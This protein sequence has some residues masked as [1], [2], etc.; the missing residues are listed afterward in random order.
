MH[1]GA[2]AG[3]GQQHGEPPAHAVERT[4]PLLVVGDLDVH[5]KTVDLVIAREV[6]EVRGDL[7]VVR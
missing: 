1:E 6:S 4:H 3:E 5:M 2:V 7:V